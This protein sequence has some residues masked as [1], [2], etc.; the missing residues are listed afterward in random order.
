MDAWSR[1]LDSVDLRDKTVLDLAAGT[2]IL[3]LLAL[4]RGARQVFA[5]DFGGIAKIA[6]AVAAENGFS[7]RVRTIQAFSTEAVLSQPVDVIVADQIG[8]FGFNAGIFEYFADA[9]RRFLA[10]G[11]VVLPYSIT[12][13]CAPV[14]APADFDRL[15]FWRGRPSGFAMHSFWDAAV[16]TLH[17]M[18][19][20]GDQLLTDP[21]ASAELLLHPTHTAMVRLQGA[22]IAR[23]DGTVHG[24]AGFFSATLAPGVSM[25]NS[26][27]APA[28]IQRFASFL[29]IE[30]PFAV[31]AGDAIPFHVLVRPADQLTS[32]TAGG[33]RHSDFREINLGAKA[34]PAG[35]P[36]PGSRTRARRFVLDRIDGAA[37][38][39][40][41]AA[42]LEASFPELFP[43]RDAAL[44]F[45]AKLADTE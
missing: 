41:I 34:D 9:T 31:R 4:Q 27:L 18:E 19:L 44:R 14:E 25:S 26:P 15:A 22:P 8:Y 12:L 17:S 10:P 32:W 6:G 16:N 36:V 39:G 21:V 28:P 45:A 20:R 30:R 43:T 11:G 3:G 1:A 33:C 40:D 38:L 42:Q 29:P 35:T 24:L 37:T 23:R 7:S 5:V 13:Q 2:G